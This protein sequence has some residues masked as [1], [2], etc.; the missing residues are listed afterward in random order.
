MPLAARDLL[1]LN[2]A[3]RP[4]WAVFQRDWYLRVHAEA[5]NA[6]AGLPEEAALAYYLRTGAKLGHS[7]SPLFDERFYL[8]RNIDVAELVRGG[9]YESGFDHYCRHGHRALSPHWLFDDAL[10]ASLYE[11]MTLE[12]L[13]QHRC[14]GRYDHYLKSGQ[15]ERRMAQFLFDGAFYRLRAIEAGVPEAEIDAVG[16][17]VHFL[18]RLGSGAPELPSSIYFEPA[19]YLDN[20]PGARPDLERGLYRSALQH[21]LCSDEPDQLDP[22][23]QFSEIFYRQNNPDVAAAVE[24][25][26]FRSGYQHFIQQGAF[27]LR[28]PAP[29]ID[30]IYYRDL[31][32]R[33]RNDLNLGEVR[34]AFA[35]LRLI[36]LKENLE[37]HPPEALPS[38]TEPAAKQAFIQRARDNLAL[39]SRRRLDFTVPAGAAPAVSVVMVLFNKFELSMGALCALRDNFHGDLE[40]ILVDNDSADD[41]RRIEDFVAGAKLLRLP[42]NIGFL[43]A[44]NAALALATAPALL[45][46]NNDVELGHAAVAAALSRLQSDPKIAAV[47]AKIIRAHGALQ[48]AGSIIWNDGMTTG[49]MRDAAPLA[50]EANFLRDVDYCSAVFL[51]CRTALVKQLG[52]FD[53]AFAPAYYEEVDLCVRL[54]GAGYRVVYD[55]LVVVHHL[56]FGSASHSEAS[57]ALMRRGR[58]TF[59]L[60]HAAFLQTRP[61]PATANQVFARARNTGR[62]RVLFLEDTVPLRRLGSGFVRANDCVRAIAAAG[63]EVSVFP[64]NGAPYQVMDLF[65][66]FPEGVEVMYDRGIMSLAMFLA[67][68]PDFYDLIWIS[69]THNLRRVLPVFET[70]RIDPGRVP[71]ILDTEAVTSARE[72][73]RRALGPGNP[74]YDLAAG[75][76]A[77]VAPAKICRRV[78]AVNAA[79]ALMLKA[80]G[81][82]RVEVLGTIAVPAPLPA[83][84]DDRAGL[85]FV[86]AMHE[87]DSPNMDALLWYV[88]EILPRLAV[89]CGGAPPVLD[90]VG[91]TAPGVDLAMLAGHRYVR[92][93]GA[94]GD[95]RRFYNAARLFIAPTR[96]AAGTPYKLYETASF[97]LPCVATGLL[98]G[99]L[100][101]QDG[102]EMLTAPVDDPERFAARIFELYRDAAL[103][104]QLRRNALARITA[105]NAPAAFNATVAGLLRG[106]LYTERKLAVVRP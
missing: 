30:L 56:E 40:L 23:P 57:M 76:L 49:Y 90:V 42:G 53:E 78:T 31:H 34:D 18:N 68:R 52:G 105:E 48:E 51:M 77:E 36:G 21:Y 32:P 62:R 16:P 59:R 97:G 14:H 50:P 99:Q 26:L 58:R 8:A 70:C 47:G 1:K 37:Y 12:N 46:L 10:Y 93:H 6:C 74:G 54:I 35:H 82:P 91:Y 5:R 102:V 22:V 4:A 33:V 96:Y 41:T 9:H 75:L 39:F 88:R 13:D 92:L 101:W 87:Q 65:G 29:D 24:N 80:A 25:G 100:G 89:Q 69:R 86:G 67:E 103:W 44:C 11:D 84:F 7:P 43:R 98:A 61:K 20:N 60:K 66:D 15:R 17:Y 27:E 3:M 104:S 2:D 55:P 38:L 28:R 45:F 85:L 106:A 71:V 95:L 73:A 72:A 63:Y 64:V 83:G 79:E 81:L 94:V 19:W